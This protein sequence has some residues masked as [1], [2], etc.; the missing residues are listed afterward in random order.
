MISSPANAKASPL[1]IFDGEGGGKLLCQW[2][3]RCIF[4]LCLFVWFL[5]T[6]SFASTWQEVLSLSAQN[7]NDINSA[8][9]QLEAYQWRYYKA[10][11]NFLPQVS[12]S[13]STGNS[14]AFAGVNNTAGYGISASLSIF[15]GMANYYN[16]R[17]N[18]VNYD[19]YTAN[20]N[21]VQAQTYYNLRQAF[22]D[23][24]LAAS[25]VEI[26]NRIKQSRENNAR[27]IKLFYDSGKEDK[28]NYLRTAAQLADA[29]QAVAAAIRQ[30]E[31][32]RLRLSQLVGAT[33]TSA[34]ETITLEAYTLPDFNA[35]AQ[36][37]PTYIMAKD[38]LTLAEIAQQNTLSEFLPSISLN[39][40]YQKSGSDW[41]SL[42]TGKSLSLGVSLPIFPGGSNIADRMISGFM[43]EKAREDLAKSQKDIFYTI[44]SAYENLKTAREAYFVQKQYLDSSVERS[45]IAQSKYLNGLMSYNDWDKIQ[46][47]YVNDQVAIIN[48]G[49]NAL[50]AQANW[51][52]S[53]GGWVK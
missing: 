29:D 15:K 32:A 47:D 48:S 21:N 38:Q 25:N 9:K 26:R 34:D 5:G 28:G 8:R 43:L 14:V 12:A 31:L 37:A 7:S 11:S 49:R 23:L 18:Q 52:Q 33:V 41:S 30:L 6:A 1:S 17:T 44:K 50:V 4:Y 3:V 53:Y 13:L 22:V 35:L 2:G 10:Y 40:S 19:L 16:L 46:N 51:L 42:S 36:Q 39:G 20:L 45:K 27:M 24:Y